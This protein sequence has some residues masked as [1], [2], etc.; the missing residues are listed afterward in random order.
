MTDWKVFA[1]VFVPRRVKLLL[2]AVSTFVNVPVQVMT[3]V[4]RFAKMPPVPVLRLMLR[5]SVTSAL[6]V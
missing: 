1:P 5:F 6:P 4:P 3:P 2:L